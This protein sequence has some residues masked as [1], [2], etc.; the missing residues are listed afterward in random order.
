MSKVGILTPPGYETAKPSIYTHLNHSA[1]YAAIVH[2]ERTE[3]FSLLSKGKLYDT[4]IYDNFPHPD[5][6]LGSLNFLYD[7]SLVEDKGRFQLTQSGKEFT[8]YIMQLYGGDYV[9][10]YTDLAS[11]T[12]EALGWRKQIEHTVPDIMQD[13]FPATENIRQYTLFPVALAFFN[14]YRVQEGKYAGKTLS[15]VCMDAFG[16]KEFINFES[17]ISKDIPHADLIKEYIQVFID[18]GLL[19]GQY[20]RA[21]VT[22]NGAHVF[23]VSAFA[24]L[25][26]SYN[27]T[28]QNLDHISSGKKSYG[29]GKDVNRLGEYNARG[30]NGI[31]GI[32]VAAQIQDVVNEM[33]ENGTDKN[34]VTIDLGSGGGLIAEKMLWKE[35]NGEYVR[36]NVNTSYGMDISHEAIAAAE[37]YV[38]EKGVEDSVRF[39]QGDI[40]QSKDYDRLN[41]MIYKNHGDNTQKYVTENFITHENEI[42]GNGILREV[43]PAFP[44]AT[45][46]ITES[47]KIDRE[48]RRKRWNYQAAIF[49]FY[50]EI[51]GQHL[52]KKE[53][54][55]DLFSRYGYT[56]LEDKVKVHSSLSGMTD[57]PKD[58]I[59]TIATFPLKY[60]GISR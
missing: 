21:T 58:K 54:L 6:I 20:N 10:T 23:Y 31:I 1:A 18:K 48:I 41:K 59:D 36:N 22:K 30:S 19:E 12:E 57:H 42:I 40:T 11:I 8:Q 33:I 2:L 34:I 45:I 51:S 38:A 44:D 39:I 53:E 50:H 16:K 14:E 47:F 17:L 46:F 52:W 35:E 7:M 29:Y 15:E 49:N 55:M 24:V 43:G 13:R 60:Q 5:R 9:D 27:S 25:H 37:K 32:R 28:M 26:V 3:L 4:D 56:V